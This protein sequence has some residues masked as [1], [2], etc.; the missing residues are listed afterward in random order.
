[1]PTP[2]GP[3]PKYNW[4]PRGDSGPKVARLPGN[5]PAF[6]WRLTGF[7]VNGPGIKG[8]QGLG[9]AAFLEAEMGLEDRREA[10]EFPQERRW[11][12]GRPVRRKEPADLPEDR[13]HQVVIFDELVDH[14]GEFRRG[15]AKRGEGLVVLAGVMGVNRAAE[16]EAVRG[17]V[18][19]ETG[20]G[21]TACDLLA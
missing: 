11:R 9:Y 15:G 13:G 14:R 17:Q 16:A 10:V 1:M 21:G 5:S 12:D 3:C 20:A 18:R 6:A 19:W 4:P 8:V 2:A 7:E